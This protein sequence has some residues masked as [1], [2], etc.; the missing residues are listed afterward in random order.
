MKQVL[1]IVVLLVL[2]VALTASSNLVVAQ[3]TMPKAENQPH[4]SAALDHLQQAEK[5]LEEASHDKGGHRTKALSL[6]KQAMSEVQQGIQYDN[7]H[8]EKPQPK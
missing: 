5:D 2:T 8:Q 4:M 7:T 6:V 3:S 1:A